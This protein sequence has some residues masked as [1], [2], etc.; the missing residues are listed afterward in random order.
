MRFRGTKVTRY[1]D[2]NSFP[3]EVGEEPTGGV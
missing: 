3:K 2:K 1:F